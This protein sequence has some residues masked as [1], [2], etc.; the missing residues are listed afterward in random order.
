M[1]FS[2][3]AKEELCR[4]RPEEPACILAEAYGVL[5]FCNS[6]GAGG[7]R[8]STQSEAFARRLP[9]LFQSAFGVEF[10]EQPAE[11]CAGK[12]IFRITRPGS[13]EE[14]MESF[15][16]SAQ[17]I[18]SHH[19]NYA[20]LE[21]EESVTAFCRGAFLAGGSVTDPGKRYHLEMATNHFHVHREFQALLPELQLSPRETR[22]KAN[23]L[24]YF[25]QSDAIAAFLR[26]IG[27]EEAAGKVLQAKVN[28]SVVNGV[29][30]QYN[31]DVANVD[32]AVAAAQTQIAAIRVL[33]QRGEL[34]HLGEKLR[35]TARLR[36]EN[37]ELSLAEL[38]ASCDPPV[39]KSCLNH[40]LRKLMELAQ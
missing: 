1:S 8:I 3:D 5:M 20:L 26:R 28:K 23:Y 18:V 34:E 35:E 31:C 32:K 17:S 25:K 38:A 37:P 39:S 40:R 2:S 10:D 14:I 6:F 22:R 21:E 36:E 29:N 19:I 4:L 16:Y 11:G 7:I 27:A 12:R 30:R 9:W 13:L 15:G 33:R 24:T